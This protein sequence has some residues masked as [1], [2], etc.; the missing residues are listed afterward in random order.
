[1]NT[2]PNESQTDVWSEW[3]LHTRFGNDPEY[4][5]M[6]RAAIDP[7]ADRVLDGARLSAGMTLVDI[8]TGDGLMAFRA[9]DTIG[10][11]LR[12]ILTDI[13]AP[14]LRHVEALAIQR[15]VQSQCRFIE[16]PAGALKDI[17]DVS[18]DVVT[19][20]A[21][22]A[23]VPDKV[24]ALR[25]FLRVLKPGGRLSIGEPI[26]RDDAFEAASLKQ[27]VDA[28]PPG[29]DDRFF[30]LLSRWKGAQFPDTEERIASNPLTNFSERDLVRFALDVGFTD[31]HMEFHVDVF[32]STVHSWEVFLGSSPHPW[33]P[34]LGRIL[35][36]RFSTEE[37]ELFE[38]IFRPRVEARQFVTAD[39]I[40][41]L[42]ARKPLS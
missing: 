40:A 26:L 1:M 6:L 14:L 37:R 25:E 33:A 13:S 3:L 36:E 31:I 29:L 4:E 7:I 24:E 34:P 2:E 16:C 23:Y 5:Q 20:R 30:P 32:P 42:T 12:V 15:N 9:I 22:L 21:V 28:Q 10:P 19:T 8:G 35:A 27:L 41:Y 18:V 17:H 39:R 38:A 11:S